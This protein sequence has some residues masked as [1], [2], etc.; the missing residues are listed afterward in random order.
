[1]FGVVLGILDWFCW[2]T[3]WSEWLS[4]RV[5]AEFRSGLWEYIAVFVRTRTIS[6][7]CALDV[8]WAMSASSA[9]ML[10]ASSSAARAFTSTI[11]INKDYIF[12]LFLG[13][14]R[15]LHAKSPIPIS[16][17]SL[18]TVADPPVRRYGGLKDQDRIFTNAYCRHDHGLKGAQVCISPCET[19]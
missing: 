19:W 5:L 13:A 12:L 2:A 7:L 1:M 16:A 18:A 3:L 11:L 14:C 17:R 8:L 9:T 10:R 4:L 15:P 6:E